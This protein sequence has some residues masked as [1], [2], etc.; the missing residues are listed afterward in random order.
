PGTRSKVRDILVGSSAPLPLSKLPTK[1][2]LL[3]YYLLLQERGYN[4]EKC[5]DLITKESLAIWNYA[6]INTIQPASAF[7]KIK[8]FVYSTITAHQAIPLCRRTEQFVKKKI[9][10]LNR[11]LNF[12]KCDHFLKAIPWEKCNCPVGVKPMKPEY[13]FLIDQNSARIGYVSNTLCPASE[14]AELEQNTKAFDRARSRA[15]RR[16]TREM[17]YVEMFC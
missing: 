2:D 5:F 10:P 14:Q 13:E 17:H 8:A 16:T 15:K 6:N 4:D 11:L 3:R 7:N 1:K 9:E 12:A